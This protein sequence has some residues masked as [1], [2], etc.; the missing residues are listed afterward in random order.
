MFL[1]VTEN[2][3]ATMEMETGADDGAGVGG[4]GLGRED[5]ELG[6]NLT[7]ERKPA[8]GRSSAGPPD[9]SGCRCR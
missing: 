2:C 9:G 3:G 5:E 7:E 6:S 4:Y 1:F 8:G